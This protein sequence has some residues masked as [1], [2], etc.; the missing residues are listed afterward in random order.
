MKV[1]IL[2]IASKALTQKPL[3]IFKDKG[4]GLRFTDCLDCSRKHVPFIQVACVLSPKGEGLTGWAAGDYFYITGVWCEIESTCI[5]FKQQEIL[6]FLYVVGLVFTNR[7]AGVIIP[8][9]NGRVLEAR[10]GHT[11]GQPACPCK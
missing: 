10:T 11:H 7:L 1:N 2:K 8:L 6:A 4:S 9:N 5:S 3:H